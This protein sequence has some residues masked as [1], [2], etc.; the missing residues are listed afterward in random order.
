MARI[1]Y[2]DPERLTGVLKDWHERLPPDPRMFLTLALAEGTAELVMKLGQA[3]HD[4]LEL[5]ERLVEIAAAVVTRAAGSTYLVE[6][7]FPHVR[8]LS[9]AELEALL[10]GADEIESFDDRD[11]AV[12]RFARALVD[13]PRIDDATFADAQLE[14]SDRELVEL[15]Q[16]HGYYSMLA[17]LD[18]AL[19]IGD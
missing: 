8:V 6:R 16:A 10:S 19:R 5:D 9:A 11:Q 12:Y 15:I 7:H 3:I 18:C 17:T 1:V 14:L 2:A 4:S 13:S